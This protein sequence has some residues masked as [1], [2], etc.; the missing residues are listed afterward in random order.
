MLSGKN[1]FSLV[2]LLVTVL[3][4]TIQINKQ[5]PRSDLRLY[6]CLYVYNIDGCLLLD[7]SSHKQT[8]GGVNK[9]T[10]GNYFETKQPGHFLT[11]YCYLEGFNNKNTK[12]LGEKQ[13]KILKSKKITQIIIRHFLCAWIS[14]FKKKSLF[15]EIVG[16]FWL[17][18]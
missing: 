15:L 1:E 13:I 4:P 2:Q 17:F 14:S 9:K 16:L 11:K 10:K 7:F 3:L 18:W 8:A 6:A 5:N 12:N